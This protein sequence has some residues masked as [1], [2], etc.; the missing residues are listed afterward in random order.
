MQEAPGGTGS[1]RDEGT[2]VEILG[3]A[4]RLRGGTPEEVDRIA[5]FVD[6]KL[7]LLRSR[8]E[9]LPLRR[10]L[11]LTS[12]NIAEDLFREREERGR[13]VEQVEGRSR[14]LRRLLEEGFGSARPP[15]PESDVEDD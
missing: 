6:E 2:M 3:E 14:E 9:A 5:R 1:S 8:H 13:L 7:S 11:I 15:A 10:L 12:L 4:F